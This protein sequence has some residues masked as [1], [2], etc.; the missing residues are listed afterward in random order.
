VKSARFEITNYKIVL[1]HEICILTLHPPVGVEILLIML[2]KHRETRISSGCMDL[3]GSLGST[4][5]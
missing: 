1:Y 4:Q 5:T 3:Y 2:Q